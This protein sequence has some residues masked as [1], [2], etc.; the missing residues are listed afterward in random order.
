MHARII[1][2]S[3][4]AGVGCA[5]VAVSALA[6][7]SSGQTALLLLGVLGV[8]LIGVGAAITAVDWL[9]S[10]RRVQ[11]R[12][13]RL[14]G[15][16]LGDLDHAVWVWQGGRREFHVDELIALLEEV[17]AADPLP[18]FTHELLVNL[19]VH[20]GDAL[21]QEPRLMRISPKLERS[22][23]HLSGLATIAADGDNRRAM[24]ARMRTATMTL[25]EL[26]GQTA[27]V[28]EFGSARE[29]RDPSEPAQRQRYGAHP[30]PEESFE[31]G[32][33]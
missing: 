3:T 24:V 5:L 22:M 12:V 13:E 31:A 32:V 15:R 4:L 7:E 1:V 19:G 28:G 18:A 23:R 9:L 2:I 8:Q 33:V 29:T 20:A 6:S 16:M 27:H 26:S 11:E 17:S 30:E 25:A 14:A 10:R 21:R